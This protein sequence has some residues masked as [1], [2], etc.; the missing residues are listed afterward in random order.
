MQYVK[1]KMG[2]GDLSI[3]A[4]TKVWEECYSQVLYI[5]N[6]NRY[7]RANLANKKDRID[8]LEKRLE[9]C[10]FYMLRL[11]EEKFYLAHQEEEEGGERSKVTPAFHL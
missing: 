7:T 9:V 1:Q 4:Y 10:Y 3:E 11:Q 6:Q 5:P 8:S 2:H